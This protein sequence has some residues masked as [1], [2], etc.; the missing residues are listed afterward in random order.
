MLKVSDD[1]LFGLDST[2]TT[3]THVRAYRALRSYLGL[4]EKEPKIFNIL[5]QIAKV[6]EDALDRLNV[7]VR[8]VPPSLRAP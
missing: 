6:D 1:L 4:S 5:E 8:C 3:G 7:N 2:A